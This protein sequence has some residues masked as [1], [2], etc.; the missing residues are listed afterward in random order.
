MRSAPIFCERKARI[1]D[2]RLVCSNTSPSQRAN[3][4]YAQ[5]DTNY[6][7]NDVKSTTNLTAGLSGGT[8]ES[9]SDFYNEVTTPSPCPRLSPVAMGYQHQPIPGHSLLPLTL[10]LGLPHTF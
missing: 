7:M 9:M 2:C 4:P 1:D 10:I 8:N 5:L 3:N 6:E